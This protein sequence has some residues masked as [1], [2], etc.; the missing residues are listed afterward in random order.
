M[1][2]AY[3]DCFSGA[4]GDMI[5][6]ALIDL[7]LSK[8]ELLNELNK[9]S[10]SGY[11]IILRDEMRMNIRGKRIEIRS[12]DNNRRGLKEI[13]GIIENSRL[14]DEVRGLSIK[15]FENIAKAEAK[16]HNVGI[17]DIH[18]HEIGAIDSIVDIVGSVIGIKY[19][20][21]DLIY[22][23]KIPVGGG[24]ISGSHG[25]FPIPAPATVDLLKNVP[26]YYNGVESEIITPTGAAILTTISS[27]FGEMPP[28]ILE[29]VGYG[30]GSREFKE[31]P[32]ILRIFTG[33]KTTGYKKDE[34]YVV[35]TNIDNMNPEFYEVLMDELFLKGA[36]DVFLTNV[37]M[38]KNR[39]GILLNVICY[40]E[41]LDNLIDVIYKSTTSIGIRYYESNRLILDRK[42]EYIDTVY[43][44][45]RVKVA[46]KNGEIIN[47]H[48]EYED[49]KRISKD[50]GISLK[51]IYNE[52]NGVMKKWITEN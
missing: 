24:L 16:I 47:Y 46:F 35:E 33:H 52:I 27:G 3:F 2:I 14:S 40:S 45:V 43:G 15:I 39:P 50:K 49:C 17:E 37:Y 10:L 19:H 25:I 26:I 31:M 48:P 21:I 51:E 29:G 32:N 13:R 44:R 11:E 18:F 6:G 1:K 20:N 28:M 30:V 22:S 36:L 34:V 9:L 4:S 38:K 5:L 8:E 23:S 12:N 42:I 41:D 7:G